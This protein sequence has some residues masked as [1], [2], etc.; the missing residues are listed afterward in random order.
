MDIYR[1]ER[2]AKKRSLSDEPLDFLIVGPAGA[3]NAKWLE[4]HFGFIQVDGSDGFN[5]TQQLSE[6]PADFVWVTLEDA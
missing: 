3:I 6:I 2:E 4:P 1:M 5:T